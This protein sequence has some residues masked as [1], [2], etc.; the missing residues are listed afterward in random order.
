MKE[1][2]YC[3][4]CGAKIKPEIIGAEVRVLYCGFGDCWKKSISSRYDPKTG[5]RQ[6]VRKYRCPNSTR[7]FNKHDDF[8][9]EKVFTMGS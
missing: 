6:Y 5:K 3:S 9:D 8:I 7:F 4:Y 1:K 2:R